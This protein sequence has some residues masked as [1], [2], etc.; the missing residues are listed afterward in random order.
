MQ[1]GGDDALL[2]KERGVLQMGVGEVVVLHVVLGVVA[3]A[4]LVAG[5][6]AAGG[7]QVWWGNQGVVQLG[8]S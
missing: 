1:W 6:S 5:C 8:S 3:R 7:A 2:M 4:V